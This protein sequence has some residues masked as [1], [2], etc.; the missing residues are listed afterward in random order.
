[1]VSAWAKTSLARAQVFGAHFGNFGHWAALPQSHTAAAQSRHTPQCRLAA[2]ERG[3]GARKPVLTAASNIV[4]RH[5][6]RLPCAMSNRPAV[7][8]RILGE[9][10]T[11]EVPIGV[12]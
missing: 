7:A 12:V 11:K 6:V 5:R 9:R 4:G 3:A 8:K 1:M 10:V 2:G